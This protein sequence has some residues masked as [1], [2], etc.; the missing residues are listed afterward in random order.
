MPKR[1]IY[2]AEFRRTLE[3][4]GL[5]P[6]Y[7]FTGAEY[8]LKEEGIRGV[9]DQALPVADRNLNLEA[10]YAGPD[11]S[12]QEVRERCQTLPFLMSRRVLIVRQVE[13]WRAPDL[14]AVSAYLDAPADSTVLIMSSSEERLKTQAWQN[15]AAKA[16]HVE[17]YPLFDNQVP[18]WIEQRSR[19]YGKTIHRD[20]VRTLVERSGQALA[21]LD[22]ELQ[23]LSVYAGTRAQITAEDVAAAAGYSRQDSLPELYAALLR[24]D[25]ALSLRL[26]VRLLDEGANAPQL[27]A[28]LAWNF[29]NLYAERRRIGEGEK[30]ENLVAEIRNPAAR[31]ERL[32]ALRAYALQEYPRLFQELLRLDDRVKSGRTHWDLELLLLIWESCA[33][34]TKL[35]ARS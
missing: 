5:K 4:G 14:A 15:I 23:K 2:Y 6:A 25:L 12:G 28:G 11:L 16:Y 35:P 3:S 17:C 20:A 33:D 8:F 34:K 7:L 13:K 10:L 29:R 32:E 18:E 31:R 21:D 24:K 9:L 26:A 22:H 1:R 19:Q 27:L 30:P